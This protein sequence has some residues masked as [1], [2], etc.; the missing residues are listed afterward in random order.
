[1]EVAA[2]PNPKMTRRGLLRTSVRLGIGAAAVGSGALAFAHYV[3]PSWLEIENLDMPLRRLPRAFDGFRI[4]QISDIHIEGN[5]MQRYFPDIAKLVTAQNADAIVLTGDYTTYPGNWQQEALIEGFRHLQ[6]PAGVWGVLGNH[7]QWLDRVNN[8]PGPQFVR[9]ALAE[10]GVREL[11]NSAHKIERGGQSLWMC[12]LDDWMTDKANLPEL[13]KQVPVG[14]A[15]ILLHHEPDFADDIAPAGRFD[16][17]LS[18]HSHGGQVALPSGKP[19]VLPPFCRKYP[20]GLY[21][22]GEM[23]LYTNRGLGTVGFPLRF[24]S[25]PEITVFTL[26]C[27]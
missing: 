17:M 26:R 3:E 1:M 18:G 15:A 23:A 14:E 12:G 19:I 10:G 11:E 8:V 22:V 2:S 6:A 5:D 25:R 16:L 7:D 13:L 20:R 24:C 9:R 27:A 4:A 21:Q